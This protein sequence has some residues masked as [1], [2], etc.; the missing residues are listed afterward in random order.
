[1]ARRTDQ[2]RYLLAVLFVLYMLSF[3]DRQVIALMVDPIRADLDISDFE[4]SLLHGFAFSIFYTLFGV[5]LGWAADRYSRRM[6]IM[7]GAS[8][9]GMMTI[10]CGMASTYIHLFLARVGVGVGEASLSPSAYSL[11]ADSVPTE[12]LPRAMS[13]Y[14]SG[15][16]FGAGAALA[17]GGMLIGALA[18][19]QSLELPVFGEVRTWQLV[20]ILC[21]LPSVVVAPLMLT[22]REPARRGISTAGAG[23]PDIGT[24]F[25]FIRSRRRFFACHFLGFSL[26]SIVGFGYASWGPAFLMRV[27][28]FEAHHVGVILG[29]M[30]LVLG[31]LSA[32]FLGSRI[33]RL[34]ENGVID[35][36]LKIYMWIGL[37]VVPISLGAYVV[38][39]ATVNLVCLAALIFMV[40][41]FS[42]PAMLAVKNVTPNEMRGQ[43]TALFVLTISLTGLGAGPTL[44]ASVTDFVFG[45]DGSVGLSLAIVTILAALISSASLRLG[46]EPY[47]RARELAREFQRA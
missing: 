6:L 12:K 8:I 32:V 4:F 41:V 31:P 38:P 27:H 9:W 23:T 7:G 18:S 2:S 45:N 46:I 47:R 25:R 10:A 22:I 33:R 30:L 34:E 40:S 43:L 39:S 21:G 26:L 35:A 3:L 37:A 24:T 14:A 1:M 29:V 28:G 13:I 20:F 42:G 36:P 19:V 17:A 16:I 44:I 5:P 15:S 11:L